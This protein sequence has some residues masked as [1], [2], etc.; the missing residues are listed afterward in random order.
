MF[1]INATKSA[2]L[3]NSIERAIINRYGNQIFYV[4][5]DLTDHLNPL[6]QLILQV[7]SVIGYQVPFN[8][9]T[10]IF[11]TKVDYSQI[12]KTTMSLADKGFISM[13]ASATN[14]RDSSKVL[15]PQY[16]FFD[17]ETAKEVFYKITSYSNRA[18]W[19]NAVANWLRD[20]VYREGE[21]NSYSDVSTLAQI[22]YHYKNAYELTKAIDFLEM[23]AE[24]SF[25]TYALNETVSFLTEALQL[26]SSY[27]LNVSQERYDDSIMY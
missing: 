23:C 5:R 21:K 3:P 19:H 18:K 22:A 7:G 11:P 12:L 25:E 16:F 24:L 8:L 10:S 17:Y 26:N 20:H 27:Q 6:E 14:L 13:A 15:T 1:D 9:L 2:E 4:V